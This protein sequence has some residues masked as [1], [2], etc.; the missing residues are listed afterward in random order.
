VNAV[1]LLVSLVGAD[2]AA[3][4][5]PAPA[6][7]HPAPAP[8]VVQSP[9][10]HNGSGACCDDGGG[11]K[12]FGRLRGLFHRD[13]CNEGCNSNH[14]LFHQPN[15]GCC[16]NGGH[17]LF[18]FLHRWRH[19]DCDDCGGGHKLI[20]RFPNAF[21]KAND[22]CHDGFAGSPA[23]T[24]I[25][26]APGTVIQP[27]PAPAKPGEKL[28]MPKEPKKLPPDEK[29]TSLSPP[30]GGLTLEAPALRPGR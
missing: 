10:Y 6:L 21:R 3:P 14:G 18:G 13:G 16:D 24:V 4:A 29:K 15:Q 11:H 8:I 5:K 27:M 20:G 26:S 1:I 2:Q 22:C 25:H 9:S 17:R 23:P 12:L 30:P 19:H 7:A 28:P